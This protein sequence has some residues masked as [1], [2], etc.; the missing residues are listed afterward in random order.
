MGPHRA[1]IDELRPYVARGQS[2]VV[3]HHLG[4]NAPHAEQIAQK[5]EELRSALS[6]AEPP[7]AVRMTRGS[8]RAFFVLPAAAHRA[9]VIAALRQFLGGP[10][11]S[12]F[13][14]GLD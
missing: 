12:L 1:R 10:W 6:L 11:Q 7:L 14:H 4:R 5:R 8:P 13:P 3:Y 9:A 2:L